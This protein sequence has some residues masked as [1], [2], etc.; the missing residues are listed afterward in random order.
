[1]ELSEDCFGTHVIEKIVSCYNQN[2]IQFI[3]DLVINNF[4]YLA[5][6][7]NGLCVV[8][9]TIIHA[10]DHQTI[11]IFKDL[12]INNFMKLVQN[13]YGNYA[14][15]VAIDVININLVLE[16]PRC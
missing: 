15:Q 11:D 4:I 10:S 1:M 9:K 13:P 3:Y 7:M 14:I 16:H 12:I 8:K 2:I 6:N 5:N